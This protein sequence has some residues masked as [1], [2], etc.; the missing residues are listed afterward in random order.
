MK[1]KE[2]VDTLK[3]MSEMEK[4]MGGQYDVEYHVG[5]FLH[6]LDNYTA[7]EIANYIAIK[8]LSMPNKD[9]DND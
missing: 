4:A 5:K 3:K 8:L 7:E 9:T 1:I 6:M 2:T